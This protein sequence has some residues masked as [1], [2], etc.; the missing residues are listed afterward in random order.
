M[1]TRLG[2]TIRATANHRFL[3]IEGWKRLDQLSAKTRIALPRRLPGPQKATMSDPELALLGHL[4]GDG[5][6]LPRHA[7]QYTTN[8]ATLAATVAGLAVEV[9]GDA[10]VPRIHQERRWYQVYLAA[11]YRLSRRKHN[12]VATWLEDLGV[13]GLRSFEKRV[14]EKVFAQPT[15][16]IARFLRHLW[17]TDGCINCRSSGHPAIY[18]ATSSQRLAHQVQSLLLRLGINGV[19][20]RHGQ[21][22][23]GRDQY[24]L[25]ITGKPDIEMFLSVV[26]G[27]GT[28]KSS[29]HVNIVSQL[30]QVTPNTNRDVLPREAWALL[31]IPAM[32]AV[33]ITTRQMQSAVGVSF[34]GSTLYKANLSRERAARVAGVVQSQ[35]LLKLARSDVYWDEIMSIEPAG[36]EEVF[37]LTV[38]GLHN[39]VAND[40]VAHNSIEQD[41]DLVLFIYRD[42]VYNKET[43]RPHVADIIVAK[44]RN[45]PTGKIH[46]FFQESLMKFLDLSV[47][48]DV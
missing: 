27:L 40:T 19:L 22:E 28:S 9:F 32:Q 7:I 25:M 17:S 44:H 47:R 26:G 46:L 29:H 24:H 8:D 13:F 35:E 16:G 48:D 12:P 41:S 4:I 15:E 34:C 18:Y 23:K 10:V 2:R 20:R 31:A 30:A 39:F 36:E 45:G 21:G 1:T 6:T 38:E 42:V 5:C 3:T 43:E 37:D 14:P 33:G 11:G